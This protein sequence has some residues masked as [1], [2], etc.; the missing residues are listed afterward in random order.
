[1]CTR[2]P[3]L[4]DIGRLEG[5]IWSIPSSNGLVI[6]PLLASGDQKKIFFFCLT[7]VLGITP[8]KYR[9]TLVFKG[10]G[11]MFVVWKFFFKEGKSVFKEFWKCYFWL[12][13]SCTKWVSSQY[14]LLVDLFRRKHVCRIGH[15][16]LVQFCRSFCLIFQFF[17]MQIARQR[18][19]VWLALSPFKST[20]PHFC[21]QMINS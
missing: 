21:C 18:K 7:Y 11:G 19:S 14:F 6:G 10:G 5:I 15:T 20:F 9:F 2:I 13:F 4:F 1:M 16:T 3:G 8:F 17:T 12:G